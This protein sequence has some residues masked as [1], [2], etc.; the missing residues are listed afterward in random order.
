MMAAAFL[1]ARSLS[2]GGLAGDPGGGESAFREGNALYQ[3]G[4][5]AGAVRAYEAVVRQGYGSGPLFY[6][7]GNACFRAGDI[8]RAILNYE[9][10]RRWMPGDEDLLHNL[11]LARRLTVDRIEPLPRFALREAHD[12]VRDALPVSGWTGMAWAGYL[13]L[14]GAA[15]GLRLSQRPRARRIALVTGAA[16]VILT[17]C[18]GYFLAARYAFQTGRD[19]AVVIAEVVRVKSA[20]GDDG[21]DAFVL[22]A[23]TCVRVEDEVGEWIRIRIADGKT[24]WIR[25]GAVT[26]V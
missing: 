26:P 9:R 19:D 14:L 18:S 13:L 24:G 7:L 12:A 6:N 21:E 22:H 5:Y 2:P 16:A 23:G 8:A 4:D 17:A 3:E 20:P 15:A 10:A 25:A 11:E 1:L